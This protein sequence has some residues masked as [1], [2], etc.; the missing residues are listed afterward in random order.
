MSGGVKRHVWA[1]WNGT[2]R[3]S[4]LQRNVQR[5]MPSQAIGH[6]PTS[7]LEAA[8]VKKLGLEQSIDDT[9]M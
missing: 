6:P 4:P 5:A 2:G 9:V 3:Q 7:H 1:R 8:I